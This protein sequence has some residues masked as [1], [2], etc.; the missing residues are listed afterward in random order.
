MYWETE[1]NCKT[2]GSDELNFVAAD[3]GVCVDGHCDDADGIDENEHAWGV[4]LS[5]CKTHNSLCLCVYSRGVILCDSPVIDFKPNTELTVTLGFLLDSD[6]ATLHVIR[7][8]DHTVLHSVPHIDVSRPLIPVF[9]VYNPGH[10][11][12]KVRVFSGSDIPVNREKMTLLSRLV[13]QIKM[14]EPL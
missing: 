12:V 7:V 2:L 13:R 5:S 11:D 10:F 1:V 8:D 14:A 4:E 6:S 9:G 3:V